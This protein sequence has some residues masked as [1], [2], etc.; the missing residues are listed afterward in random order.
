MKSQK[1]ITFSASLLSMTLVMTG[2]ATAGQKSTISENKMPKHTKT[3]GKFHHQ[4]KHNFRKN[5]EKHSD[6][7]EYHMKKFSKDAMMHGRKNHMA[8][9]NLTDEQKNQIKLLNAQHTNK[10]VQIRATLK[11][12][13]ENIAKQKQARADNETLINLYQQKQA[14]KEQLF[15]LRQQQQQQ[16]MN[17]LTPEQ[18]LKLY[19]NCSKG[20]PR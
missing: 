19:E 5:R 12:H 2:C 15:A 16:F 8:E 20:L 9:L 1:F 18:Q 4:N 10:M 6:N 17:I 7:H 14:V 11:Q 3:M 13:D